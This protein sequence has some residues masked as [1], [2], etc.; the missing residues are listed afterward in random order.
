MLTLT[1]FLSVGTSKQA[2][3][4]QEL[5]SLSWMVRSC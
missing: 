3:H 5:Y 4:G 2:S 1:C